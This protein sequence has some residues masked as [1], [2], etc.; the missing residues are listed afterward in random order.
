MQWCD[1]FLITKISPCI[2]MLRS[3]SSV[4]MRS[5]P[6]IPKSTLQFYRRSGHIFGWYTAESKFSRRCA[7]NTFES[8]PL[9]PN[10]Y[11]LFV[12]QSCFFSI[13]FIVNVTQS[14]FL[15]TFYVVYVGVIHFHSLLWCNFLCGDHS[16]KL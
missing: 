3:C 4:V 13:F 5:F 6:F 7:F 2:P 1:C 11:A 16:K 12:N 15:H 9:F 14:P 10:L 8:I